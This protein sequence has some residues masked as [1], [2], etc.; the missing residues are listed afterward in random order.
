MNMFF[1]ICLDHHTS[2]DHKGSQGLDVDVNGT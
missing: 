2:R 1:E